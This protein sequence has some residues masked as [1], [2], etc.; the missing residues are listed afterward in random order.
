[1]SQKSL[2]TVQNV[3]E[4]VP[5]VMR[6]IRVKFRERRAANVNVPQ[7]RVMA[8]LEINQGA[9]LSELA[10]SVGLTLPAM[11]SLVDHL[12]S[13]K[14]ITRE[15]SAVDRRKVHLSLTPEGQQ[16][17]NTAYEY[18]QRFLEDKMSSLSEQDLEM[19]IRSMQILKG[20]FQ[21]E[22]EEELA[23]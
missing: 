9:T 7:F 5:L 3:I 13:R 22:G 6:T 20:L 4:V 16:E 11:S 12:V 21:L 15:K 18:T 10:Y 1:M 14:L 17:L 8:Y 2:L 19:I 23:F